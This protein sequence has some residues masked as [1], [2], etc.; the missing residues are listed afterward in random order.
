MALHFLFDSTDFHS[1]ADGTKAKA[2]AAPSITAA[3]EVCLLFRSLEQGLV[4]W[5]RPTMQVAA[6]A[7]EL[8]AVGAVTSAPQAAVCVSNAAARPAVVVSE[9]FSISSVLCQPV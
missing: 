6:K 8:P 2:S 1:R 4:S 5:L 3:G 9:V 7:A